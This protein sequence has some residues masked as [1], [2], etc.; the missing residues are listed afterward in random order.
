MAVE[1]TPNGTYGP[2]M[3]PPPRLL[4]GIIYALITFML[5]RQGVPV[6]KLTTTGAKTGKE[7]TTPLGYFPDGENAWLIVGSN[8]GSAKHPAWV[9]NLARNPDKA[10]IE[11]DHRKIQVTPESLKGAAYDKAWNEIAAKAPNYGAYK[12]KTDRIIPI[13]RLTPRA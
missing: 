6:F 1:I 5:T 12:G 10:W 2:N 7:H 8:G 13:I 4:R 9:F 3:P 11:I